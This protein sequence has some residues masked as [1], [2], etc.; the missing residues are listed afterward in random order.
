[1]PLSSKEDPAR[2]FFEALVEQTLGD[3]SV[4]VSMYD[5]GESFGWE[6][7]QA[8]RVAEELIGDGWV[9]VKTLS[10]GIALTEEGLAQVKKERGG[11]EPGGIRLG[12]GPVLAETEKTAVDRIVAALKL[13]AGEKSWNFDVLSEVMAD[14]R[15]LDAQL[16]SPQPK[17]AIIRECLRSLQSVLETS[18]FRGDS[19]ET[20]HRMLGDEQ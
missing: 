14:L 13:E 20:I 6:R 19:L 3:P 8:S 2:R 1:M 12:T 18:G 17:A 11:F 10:G 9:E 7:D 16:L 4:T 15:T 5:L